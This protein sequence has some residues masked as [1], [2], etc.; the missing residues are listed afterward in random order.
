[1]KCDEII[2]EVVPYYTD[3]LKGKKKDE[4]KTHTMVCKRCARYAYKARLA[5]EF[6]K[7]NKQA[8]TKIDLMK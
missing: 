8:V 1:V 6:I 4:Y 3:E 7:K 2:K 5:I